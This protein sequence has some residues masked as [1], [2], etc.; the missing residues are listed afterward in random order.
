MKRTIKADASL[1][2]LLAIALLCVAGFLLTLNVFRS[3]PI[4]EALASENVINILFILEGEGKPLGAYVVMFSPLNNRAAAIAIPGD[5]GLILKTQDRVDRIDSAY[6]PANIK[7]LQLEIEGLLDLT[8]NY[9][10]VL[11]KEKLAK[12]IDL[13]GGV[14]IFI[15]NAIEIYEEEILLFPSG[16]TR[17]DGDKGIQYIEFELPGETQND[18]NLRRERFFLGLLRSLGEKNVLLKNPSV[19]RYFYPLLKTAMSGITR[20]RLFESLSALDIDRISIQSVAGTYREISGQK[21]LMPYYD[22]TVIK[23]VVRQAQRSLE[24]KNQGTLME[25]VFT[26]EILNGTLTTGLAS[27][28]A[29]LIRGFNYDVIATGNAERNDYEKTEIIDRTGQENVVTT[30]AGIIRCTNIRFESKIPEEDLDPG[31][32]VRASE[33]KADFTLIIGRDFNGRIVTGN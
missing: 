22:G 12:I 23:D 7:P 8:I 24:Q 16:N 29:E 17:L 32:N 9:S 30:F 27:R 5:V 31:L 28:T 13:I 14:E 2:L 10:V 19:A 15:P 21:L 1:F 26:V 20:R 11:E 18:I 4:E 33:Y 25:R 3:D 6:D